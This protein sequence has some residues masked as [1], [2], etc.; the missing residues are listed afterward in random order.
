M[1]GGVIMPK[2]RRGRCFHCTNVT[3]V[4]QCAACRRHY[5]P[6]CFDK[7]GKVYGPHNP[8]NIKCYWCCDSDIEYGVMDINKLNVVKDNDTSINVEVYDIGNLIVVQNVEK[9]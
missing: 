2:G 5:C 3:L 4:W 8:F 9:K 1:K 6:S 7:E